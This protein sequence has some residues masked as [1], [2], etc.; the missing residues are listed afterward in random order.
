MSD[1][2]NLVGEPPCDNGCVNFVEC[3]ETGYECAR[4]TMY[5]G[6]MQEGISD[7]RKKR[8]LSPEDIPRLWRMRVEEKMSVKD[9]AR[10][11]GRGYKTIQ[12]VFKGESW[13]KESREAG[14]LA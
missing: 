8:G 14:Y 2:R 6:G 4:F 11:M 1:V 13:M 12:Q 10:R 3:K 9:I 5:V 7:D